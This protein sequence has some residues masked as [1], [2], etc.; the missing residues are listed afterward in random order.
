MSPSQLDYLAM[1]GI[2]FWQ[3]KHPA[4]IS[5]SQNTENLVSLCTIA[6]RDLM[7]I[8]DGPLADQADQLLDR[9]LQA[10]GLDRSR[11]HLTLLKQQIDIIQPKVILALGQPAAQHLL[12]TTASLE[13]VR[14]KLHTYASH[15][16]LIATYHP[17]HLL[18]HSKDKSKAWQDLQMLQRLLLV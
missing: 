2:Q 5:H 13:E 6:A 11:V 7:L 3:E 8:V 4:S 15:I 1:M 14:G 18:L 9:M 12:N 10:I 16:P 17:A